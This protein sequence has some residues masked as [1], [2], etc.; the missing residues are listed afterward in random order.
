MAATSSH[1]AEIASGARFGFGANWSR[2]LEHLDASRIQAAERSLQQ[3]LGLTTLEG[4]RFLDA[5]SG[6]GLFSLAARRL[7]AKVHAFDFDPQSVACT[8]ALLQQHAAE[9]GAARGDD[10]WRVEEGSV[11]D[12]TYLASLG[13]FDIV[14]SW[15]VLHH[16]GDQWTA[17]DNVSRL[18]RPKGKLF[19]AIYNDQGGISRWW[20]A[21]KRLYNRNALARLLLIVLYT[22]YFIWLRWVYRQL[23]GRG[24]VERGMTLW[25]DMIDW[26]GGYPFEVAKPEAVF[27]FFAARGFELREMTTAGRTGACNEF[28][29][30]RVREAAP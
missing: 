9:S 25:Y 13:D 30:E 1:A 14:Y 27:R 10:S 18:V 19:I 6:S 23:T 7:G 15:G 12:R 17:M 21:V 29:F 3:M 11:L 26:L 5:G 2:F 22:P 4:L 16:T 20:T 24:K 28:V 8:R